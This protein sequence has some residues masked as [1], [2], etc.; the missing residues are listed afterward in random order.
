MSNIKLGVLAADTAQRDAI[1]IAIASVTSDE[2]LYPGDHI[3][4]VEGTI[5]KV[6]SLRGAENEVAIGIV[7]PFLS[8]RVNPGQHFW[9]LL[10]PQ[11]ITSLRHEWTHPAFA[12]VVDRVAASRQWLRDKAGRMGVAYEDLIEV[13]TRQEYRGSFGTDLWSDTSIEPELWTHLEIVTGISVPEQERPSSFR[14]AC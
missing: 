12:A 11:T 4:L 1:H 14:C 5:D 7:D 3:A 2:A 10:Y 6:Q 9:L 8:G 13:T